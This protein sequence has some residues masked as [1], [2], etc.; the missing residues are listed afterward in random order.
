M[1]IIKK[2]L[3]F[4]MHYRAA[5]FLSRQVI[6]TSICKHLTLPPVD[7]IDKISIDYQVH[8]VGWFKVKALKWFLVKRLFCSFHAIHSLFQQNYFKTS[9]QMLSV[10]T[11]DCV[12]IKQIVFWWHHLSLFLVLSN[13]QLCQCVVILSRQ[14]NI[15]Y[16][17]RLFLV[18]RGL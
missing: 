7:L 14:L 5:Y 11:C 9:F 12:C 18:L 13:I 16:S 3:V 15:T 6:Y 4:Q 17:P 1:Q 10:P 8:C 2:T